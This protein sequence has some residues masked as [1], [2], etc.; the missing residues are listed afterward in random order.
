MEWRDSI[1]L[2]R[3]KRLV[4][5]LALVVLAAFFPAFIQDFLVVSLSD[6]LQNQNVM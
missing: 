4:D 2:Y 3:V 6:P 1:R 5:E